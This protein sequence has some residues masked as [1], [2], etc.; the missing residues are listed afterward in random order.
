MFAAAVDGITVIQCADNQAAGGLCPGDTNPATGTLALAAGNFAGVQLSGSTQT[1]QGTPGN[2]NPLNVLNSSSL[3]ILNTTGAP[4]H[5]QAAAGDTFFGAPVS[6]FDTSA[7]GTV[8]LGIG[9]TFDYGFFN[10]PANTQGATFP[11]DAPGAS[12]DTFS[13][14][15]ALLADAFAHSNS[16]SVT[17]LAP[18]S[19]SK[20]SIRCP[21]GRP[22]S[23]IAN[24]NQN[25][26]RCPFASLAL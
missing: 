25:L 5:I 1:S 2:P 15:A 7:S 22:S 21:A 8:Q 3:Q 24:R 16:G 26:P 11:T 17:D 9:S 4:V 14:T 12:I 20:P 10:D 18:F 13:F 19:M 23:V 6:S